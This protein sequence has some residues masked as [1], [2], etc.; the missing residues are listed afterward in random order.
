MRAAIALLV[1]ALTTVTAG[2]AQPAPPQL[3]RAVN[4]FAGI[5]DPAS[6][7]QLERLITSLKNASGD[8]VVVATV[9]T[10]E[11]Y[12]DIREFA[13]KMF[14]NG[15]RGVGDKGK[16]NGLLIVVAVQ[17]RK[18]AIEVGYDLEQFITDGYAGQTIRER[19]TPQFRSGDYG[20]GLIA[21]ASALVNR[22]AAGRGVQLQGVQREP[23][24]R[25]T[26]P[27]PFW[28]FI[29]MMIIFMLMSRRRGRRGRHWGGGGWSSGVGPF[30]GGLGGGGFGGGFG[31]FGG[32]GF[33]GGGGGFGGFGGGRSGGGGASGSW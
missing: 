2:A 26:Q 33:G 30:G 5:I 6:E 23:V 17:E 28:P 11:G 16:D 20:A 29:I 24:R 25:R 18:V 13:V 9:P 21:G 10:I 14:E 27:A 22:I 32:G 8:V 1:A 4:D 7:E 15:G 12:M 3:T 31:G 19:I